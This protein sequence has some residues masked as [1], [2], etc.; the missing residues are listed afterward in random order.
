M[1][2]IITIMGGHGDGG[3]NVPEFGVAEGALTELR[4][5]WVGSWSTKL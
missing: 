1:W 3:P 5:A 2:N 4:V